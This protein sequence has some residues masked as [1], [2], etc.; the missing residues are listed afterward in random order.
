LSANAQELGFRNR[1][2]RRLKRKRD[3]ALLDHAVDVMPPGIAIEK[4]DDGKF[5]FLIESLQKAA[6]PARRL[7]GSMGQN[8]VVLFPETIFVEAIPDRAFFDMQHEFGLAF[9]ELNH[10]RFDNGWKRISS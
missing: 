2:A 10:I 3:R 8:A 1:Q 6:A 9:L 7:S 4:A 5:E